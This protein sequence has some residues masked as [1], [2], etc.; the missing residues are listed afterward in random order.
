[1]SGV[2]SSIGGLSVAALCPLHPPLHS[3]LHSRP[4]PA[5]PHRCL[6]SKNNGKVEVCWLV[7]H[8]YPDTRLFPCPALPHPFLQPASTMSLDLVEVRFVMH[9]PVVT[10]RE[11]MRLG[12]VR[13]VLCCAVAAVP[14]GAQLRWGPVVV[15]IPACCVCGSACAPRVVD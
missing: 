9:A 10:L 7:M 14:R 3:L 6:Q 1:M 13:W 4:R 11:Q 5:R 2:G 8:S 12:D 15:S